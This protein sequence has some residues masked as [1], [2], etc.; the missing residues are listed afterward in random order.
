MARKRAPK[1]ITEN[2][3]PGFPRFNLLPW[4]IRHMIWTEAL[5]A[6]IPQVLIYK[7]TTFPRWDPGTKDWDATDGP[8]TIPILPPAILHATQES[9]AC[10]L[11]QILVRKVKK[12]RTRCVAPSAYHHI[13]SRPFNRDMDALFVHEEHFPAF[14]DIYMN[15]TPSAA[16]HLL[17]DVDIHDRDGWY[18]GD[19]IWYDL[20]AM[21][22]KKCRGLR[23]VAVV[24]LGRCD[25]RLDAEAVLEREPRG[26]Y[27]AVPDAEAVAWQ[28]GLGQ[29][30]KDEF[31]GHKSSDGIPW[32]VKVGSDGLLGAAIEEEDDDEGILECSQVVLERLT[33]LNVSSHWFEWYSKRLISA[34]ES[35]A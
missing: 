28:E 9:R 24:G 3:S 29:A 16:R 33:D 32:K 27:R 20:P 25:S 1:S 19:G 26:Y 11:E 4:E 10:A 6:P 22:S 15:T 2:E 5:P 21:A 13:V 18:Y 14:K 7:S 23:S 30:L 8:P 31:R 34:W 12:A 35:W 17:F